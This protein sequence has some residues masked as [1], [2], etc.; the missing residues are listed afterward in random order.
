MPRPNR[1][2]E[3]NCP[4]VNCFLCIIKES[5]PHKR[6]SGLASFFEQLPGEPQGQGF[7]SSAI[8]SW[9]MAHPNDPELVQQGAFSAM[10]A[11]INRGLEYRRWL[12][13]ER[14]ELLSIEADQLD[15][16]ANARW[17]VHQE[18]LADAYSGVQILGHVSQDGEADA[19]LQQTE[20][21]A[22]TI[23]QHANL[24]R[25]LISALE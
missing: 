4:K 18:S 9:A 12:L 15:V 25:A 8:W 6:R 5:N 24:I 3:H 21:N 16:F 7:S 10:A 14:S 13:K 17:I 1:E 20:T 19:H 2:H 22:E 11:L 23:V